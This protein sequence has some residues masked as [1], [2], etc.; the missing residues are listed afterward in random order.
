MSGS[1]D[2]TD[3]MEGHPDGSYEKRL[4]ESRKKYTVRKHRCLDNLALASQVLHNDNASQQPDRPKK[5]LSLFH[6]NTLTFLGRLSLEECMQ[7][8]SAVQSQCSS[9]FLAGSSSS[10]RSQ[11]VAWES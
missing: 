1:L 7:S 3:R 10:G 9:H 5:N 11:N 6:F 2:K 8:L 4:R